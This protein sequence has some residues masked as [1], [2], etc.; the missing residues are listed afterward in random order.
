MSNHLAAVEETAFRELNLHVNSLDD[1]R[2]RKWLLVSVILAKNNDT[3]PVFMMHS[4]TFC[5][6]VYLSHSTALWLLTRPIVPPGRWQRTTLLLACV[7]ACPCS[8]AW[9]F[10]WAIYVCYVSIP[11]FAGVC[12]CVLPWSALS[13]PGGGV[14]Q[15]VV[16]P[17]SSG[18][19][20][21]TALLRA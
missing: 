16:R 5:S 14:T 17:E 20:S 3:P 11:G 2:S 15:L 8:H 7:H 12:V 21:G 18:R 9:I 10:T 19:L 6:V 13:L 1:Q 4:G